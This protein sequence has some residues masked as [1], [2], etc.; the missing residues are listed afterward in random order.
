MNRDTALILFNHSLTIKYSVDCLT[1]LH[2]HRVLAILSVFNRADIH[3][4]FIFAN[5][6][7]IFLFSGSRERRP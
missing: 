3:V 6:A 5:K 7:R 1:L 2:L 4:R